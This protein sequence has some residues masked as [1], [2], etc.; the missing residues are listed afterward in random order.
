MRYLCT[1]EFYNS[2]VIQIYNNNLTSPEMFIL[3]SER[4]FALV[5][6]VQ[7]LSFCIQSYYYVRVATRQLPIKIQEAVIL[8]APFFGSTL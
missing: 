4:M 8:R 1:F 5:Q 6:I 2:A 7:V 3:E